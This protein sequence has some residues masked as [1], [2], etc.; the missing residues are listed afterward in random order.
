MPLDGVYEPPRT[1]WVREQVETYERSG[2][3]EGNTFRDLPIIVVTTRGNRTGKVRKTPLMRIEHEGRYA[4]VGSQGGAP[5][6]PDWCSNLRAHPEDVAI[7]D[8]PEPFD[9]QVRELASAER[10]EWWNRALVAYPRLGGLQAKTDRLLPIFL[11]ARREPTA[12]G[13]PA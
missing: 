9:A 12:R 10:D 5:V 4:L 7:Q 11:A 13:A 8:G 6:D 1:D 2:G 3:R